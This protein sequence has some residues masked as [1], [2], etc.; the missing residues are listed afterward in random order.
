M[1][2]K[3]KRHMKI[4]QKILDRES[5]YASLTDQELQNKTALFKSRLAS[6][7][8][9]DNL[10]IDAYA[11]MR[12]A[13]RRILGQFPYPNQLL[14]AI[15]LH[16]GNIAA[17]NTG[18]GKSLTATLPLYLHALEGKGAF[19][20]TVN[21]YLARRDG[22]EY[23]SVYE[24][25]GLTVRIGVP[26][27][28]QPDFSND[29]KRKIYSSDVI[30][31]TCDK[32]GFDYLLENLLGTSEEKYLRPYDYALIDEVDAVLLD[33][34]QMPLVISGSPRVQSNLYQHAKS[35][36]DTLRPDEE[37]TYDQGSN[38]VQLTD[39]GI[40]AANRYFHVENIYDAQH[41]QLSRHINLALRAC[42]Q[43]TP[44]RDYMIQAKKLILLSNVTGRLLEGNKLQGG[45]HQAI[46]AKEDVPVSIENRAMASITYQN[47]FLKFDR[48]SGMTGTVRGSEK[49]LHKLYGTK[50]VVIPPHKPLQRIDEPDVV[51]QTR[52][53]KRD[54]I[55]AFVDEMRATGR[56]ILLTTNSVKNSIA[57]SKSLLERGIEH[58][59]LSALSESRE[60]EMVLEAG[61]PGTLTVATL[62]AG[63]GT[64]IK[65]DPESRALGGLVII[66]TEKLDNRRIEGQVR[67]RAGRQGDPGTSRFYASME[68]DL[69]IS[70][71]SLT[72]DTVSRRKL[73]QHKMA[74][75]LNRAQRA[76]EDAA[77]GARRLS[78]DFDLAASTQR[79]LMYE[80][81]SRIMNTSEFSDPQ[82]EQI[83]VSVITQ[84][85]HLK[86]LDSQSKLRRYIFDNTNYQ[87]SAD[88]D[89]I[90]T[91]DSQHVLDYV[92]K[93]FR[94]AIDAQRIAAGDFDVFTK[95]IRVCFLKAIDVAWVEQVDFLEQLK[96]VVSE[97]NIAQHQVKFEYRKEA[98]ASFNQMKDKINQDIIR[99][100]CLSRIEKD[101]TGGL[102]LQFA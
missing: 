97:R 54:H 27:V 86:Q 71:G 100:V 26:D 70:H 68:D 15:A 72:Q 44:Q 36:I 62:M 63:R 7:D 78:K 58:N 90:D 101:L 23:R 3:S 66:G 16:Q 2:I 12:E 94:Q 29:D 56:P 69:F 57:L 33:L 83:A 32:I 31:T 55:L 49:E 48:I 91:S 6:G 80:Q 77:S 53:E 30:Y 60:S 79:E 52:E 59:L 75:L 95:F 47:L 11:T 89:S 46:E 19:L 102:V 42:A 74:N 96:T 99:L 93:L 88:F 5:E 35:F 14:A 98:Y 24:F 81:R 21:S 8:S 51:L 1:E 45:L 92:L 61:R 18:E 76:S 4:V 10:L 87:I 43:F 37:F 13:D 67:G 84:A 64:D 17:L 41:F 28:D 50:V 38:I 20:I 9:L 40:D 82:L 25:M 65:L 39:S 73:S 22:A 34:A 85:I